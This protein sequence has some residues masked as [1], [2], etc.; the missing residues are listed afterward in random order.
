MLKRWKIHKEKKKLKLALY[1]SAN[2]SLKRSD[3]PE[4]LRVVAELLKILK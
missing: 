2:S 3:S 1:K 4:L